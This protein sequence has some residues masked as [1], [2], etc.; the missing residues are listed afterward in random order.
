METIYLHTG[1]NIG[2]RLKYL[3]LSRFF[4]EQKIGKITSKS[5]IYE[6]E[7]WGIKNQNPFF[8]QA[9]QVETTLTSQEVLDQIH[10]IEAHLGR[11]RLERWGARTID[12]DILFYGEEII[13]TETL[14]IPHPYLHLRNFVL[15]PMNEIVPDLMHKPLNKSIQVLLED[16]EDDLKVTRLT[17]PENS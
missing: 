16:C 8:N 12:I 6:C 3:N 10:Q 4:I 14:N 13:E 11:Q 2:D 1:S 17:N 9:M 15:I 5:A 7:S